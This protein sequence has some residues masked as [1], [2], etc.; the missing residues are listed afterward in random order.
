MIN[1][2]VYIIHQLVLVQDYNYG[3]QVAIVTMVNSAD[4]GDFVFKLLLLR[5]AHTAGCSG[6]GL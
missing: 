2:G 3:A 5:M 6:P 1:N 4:S